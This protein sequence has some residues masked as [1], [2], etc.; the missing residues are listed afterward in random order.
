[1]CVRSTDRKESTMDQRLR[2]V[3]EIIY[4]IYIITKKGKFERIYG[5]ELSLRRGNSGKIFFAERY[6]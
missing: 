4:C 1:M 6:D 3:A 5:K 2:M